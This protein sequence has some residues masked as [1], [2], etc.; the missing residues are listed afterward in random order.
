[1]PTDPNPLFTGDPAEWLK[2][3]QPYQRSSVDELLQQGK[4]YE[5]IADIWL[6]ARPGDTFSFG[7]TVPGQRGAFREK[8]TLEVEAFLCGDERYATERSKLFGTEGVARTY[9]VSAIAVAVAPLLG[10]SAT[11]LAPVV[12]LILAS[13]GKITLNAWC[14]ARKAARASSGSVPAA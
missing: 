1:M 6:A 11:F 14:A 5:E 2:A 12:G 10:V 13:I 3:L 9:V 8:L 4:S 7:T